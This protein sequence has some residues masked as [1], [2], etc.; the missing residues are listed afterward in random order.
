[1]EQLCIA[2]FSMPDSVLDPG[3]TVGGT[4]LELTFC[5]EIH[6]KLIYDGRWDEGQYSSQSE[7][8]QR[9]YMPEKSDF[10]RG[11]FQQK[12]TEDPKSLGAEKTGFGLF[13]EQQKTSVSGAK[14]ARET[15]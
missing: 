10:R 4:F 11:V 1:M 14:E 3:G 13:T 8:E 15:G 2:T 12:T 9:P 5:W 7:I 6:D